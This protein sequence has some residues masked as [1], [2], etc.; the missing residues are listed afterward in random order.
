MKTITRHALVDLL[1]NVKTPQPIGLVALTDAGARKTGNP[2][3]Q[4]FKLSRVW[5]F[6]GK[7]Y[8]KAVNAQLTREGSEAAFVP[9]SPRYTR[10]S[11]ALV[12][13]ANGN[14]AVPV[15]FNSQLTQASRPRY[16]ARKALL[17][18]LRPIDKASVAPFL[19]VSAPPARQLEAGIENPIV[20][21][22]YGIASILRIAIGGETYR[23]RA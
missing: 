10:I 22:T 19:P 8:G 20:W 13:F 14:F 15:Q 3:V 9:V 11:A 21:R 17:A 23:V 5:P 16:F 2:Y 18:P 1:A 7:D 6:I 12:K 4:T